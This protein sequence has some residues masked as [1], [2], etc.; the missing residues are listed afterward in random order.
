[1]RLTQVIQVRSGW[2]G[3]GKSVPGGRHLATGDCFEALEGKARQAQE[4]GWKD[5]DLQF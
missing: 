5:R 1:M 3:Q 4:L 2:G